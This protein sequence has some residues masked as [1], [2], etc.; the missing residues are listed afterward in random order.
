MADEHQVPKNSRF[1]SHFSRRLIDGIA[2]RRDTA[3]FPMDIFPFAFLCG[4]ARVSHLSFAKIAHEFNYRFRVRPKRNEFMSLEMRNHHDMAARLLELHEV[5]LACVKQAS[6]THMA[7]RFA[8]RIRSVY[9]PI[10]IDSSMLN[11]ETLANQNNVSTM[12]MLIASSPSFFTTLHFTL[13]LFFSVFTIYSVIRDAFET[14]KIKIDKSSTHSDF[15]PGMET[16]LENNNK[17]VNGFK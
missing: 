1:I 15:T 8:I 6:S 17:V 3:E 12:M 16:Q 2:F 5:R 9:A 10:P 4:I 11:C 14:R 13:F 7:H